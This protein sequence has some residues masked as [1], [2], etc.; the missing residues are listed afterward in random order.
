MQEMCAS[1]ALGVDER[2]RTMALGLLSGAGSWVKSPQW[3]RAMTAAWLPQR[4]REEFG[5]ALGDAEERIVE[6]AQWWLPRVYRLLPSSV[7]FTGPYHEARAR[8]A[9][10]RP[11]MLTQ[12]SNRF[13]MGE[14]KMPFGE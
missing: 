12:A 10:R 6:K 11:G 8:L 3:Y 1:A 9:G 4:L 13:W 5:L 7:R 2:A 14:E